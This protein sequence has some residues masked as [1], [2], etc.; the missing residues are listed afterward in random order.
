MHVDRVVLDHLPVRPSSP[1]GFDDLVAASPELEAAI[2]SAYDAYNF[3]GAVVMEN[4][5][6]EDDA[7]LIALC[8]RFG[9]VTKED[10]GPPPGVLVR[11]LAWGPQDGVSPA[12]PLHTDSAFVERPHSALALACARNTAGGW[13]TN[14][15]ARIDDAIELLSEADCALLAGTPARFT[16]FRG[17]ELEHEYTAPVLEH[18]RVGAT[19]RLHPHQLT[20]VDV[21]GPDF[22]QAVERLTALLRDTA[23]LVKLGA[24]DVLVLDNRRLVHGRTALGGRESRLLRRLKMVSA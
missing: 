15:L 6:V 3:H 16:K 13:G 20:D 14:L 21:Y 22:A 23:Q 5:P 17:D 4:I 9:R 11:D 1:D 12:M 18:G 24:G 19:C 7:V 10:N 2:E 8:T